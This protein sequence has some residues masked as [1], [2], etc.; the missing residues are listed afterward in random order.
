MSREDG[1]QCGSGDL[2]W[3][4]AVGCRDGDECR[5]RLST[6]G[7]LCIEL[8]LSVNGMFTGVYAAVA[9]GVVGCAALSVHLF[10]LE[11]RC[12]PYQKHR[13]YQ[14]SFSLDC[15]TT[16]LE[17]RS[18]VA[19]PLPRWLSMGCPLRVHRPTHLPSKSLA[20]R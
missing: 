3:L 19:G 4:D 9:S 11:A 8:V 1:G 2:E 13:E 20:T 14:T 6:C 10:K 16:E 7:E 18:Y 15:S 5:M 17:L 12:N